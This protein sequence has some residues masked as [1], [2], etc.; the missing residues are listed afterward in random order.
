MLDYGK[1]AVLQSWD[2]WCNNIDL[3]DWNIRAWL[4]VKSVKECE[5]DWK[6]FEDYWSKNTSDDFVSKEY[7]INSLQELHTNYV[8][9]G[10]NWP[11]L[12]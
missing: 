11:I 12:N 4:S 8:K 6:S 3:L 5:I 10:W 9:N 2:F 1:L 7:E